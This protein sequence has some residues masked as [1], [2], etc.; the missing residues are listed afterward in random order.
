M[1][2]EAPCFYVVRSTFENAKRDKVLKKNGFD[3]AAQFEGRIERKGTH[4]L[5]ERCISIIDG[6]VEFVLQARPAATRVTGMDNEIRHA[7]QRLRHLL[8]SLH[9]AFSGLQTK[10][11]H[12]TPE[13]L[14]NTKQYHDRFLALERYL[15]T[16]ITTKSHWSAEHSMEQ[17]EALEGTGG[18]G[19][20]CGE[21]NHQVKQKPIE[22]SD[23]PDIFLQER[24]SRAKKKSRERIKKCKPKL[25]RSR[26]SVK[27]SLGR[28]RSTP[29]RKEATTIGSSRSNPGFAHTSGYDDHIAG[30]TPLK[31]KR[32]I[33][34]VL[35]LVVPRT[36]NLFGDDW[37][38][39]VRCGCLWLLSVVATMYTVI[40]SCGFIS[41]LVEID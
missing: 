4:F 7:G 20:D 34:K 38:F 41:Y 27:G 37:L 21:R 28:N 12:F 25:S 5:M 1:R 9:G 3:Q 19:E 11:F 32:S 30:A 26:E 33:A 13:I 10:H 22:V 8:L 40:R 17:Q 31:I 35:I 18:M 16:S 24:R 15:C 23:V 14:E 36:S 6:M 29:S 39:V 2:R